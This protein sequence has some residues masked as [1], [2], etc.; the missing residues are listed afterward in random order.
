MELVKEG[1]NGGTNVPYFVS[2]RPFLA[3]LLP[4]FQMIKVKEGMTEGTTV[5]NKRRRSSYDRW[6]KSLD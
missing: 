1:M 5:T 2:I 6:F 4:S 3:S